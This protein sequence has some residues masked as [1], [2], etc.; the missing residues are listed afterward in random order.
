M[1]LA[2]KIILLRKKLG[3]SQEQLAEQMDIS[4]Q[5]VSKWESG[6]SIPDLDKI[7]KLSKL[8]GVSTDYLLKDEIEEA[9][10]VGSRDID[11]EEGVR[12]ISAEEASDYMNLSKEAAPKMALATALCI[13]SPICLIVLGGLS[14]YGKLAMSED[15]AGG[16]GFLILLLFVIP[17]V[18]IFIWKGMQMDKYE[19]L[20]KQR[21]ELQYGVQGIVEKK[22]AEFE[23]S[24]R[25]CITAGTG[26][27]I[28]AVIPLFVGAALEFSDLYLVY[29]VAILLAIIACGVLLF[30]WS[31]TIQESF[32]KLLEVGDYTRQKKEERKYFRIF[33][34]IYWCIVTAVYLCIML[35]NADKANNWREDLSWVIWPVAGVLF[36]AITGVIRLVVNNKNKKQA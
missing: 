33:A 25:T 23:K 11:T 32:D 4:R 13:L 20:E 28:V 19:F 24:Y 34:G 18:M 12:S 15:A 26:L 17:A 3:W 21:V 29:C 6:A 5:S 36:G 31:C 22:K 30:V 2:D 16:I 27:C 1:I 14:E 7:I 35:P 10:I 8:F 9:E